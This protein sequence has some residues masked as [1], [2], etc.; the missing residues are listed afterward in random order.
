MGGVF[1]LGFIL[2]GDTERSVGSSLVADFVLSSLSLLPDLS[3]IE[4]YH[5][6]SPQDDQRSRQ[7]D[8]SSHSSNEIARENTRYVFQVSQDKNVSKRSFSLSLA[9]SA[10]ST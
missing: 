7:S 10:E 9:F 8:L 3:E 5:S 1:L 4:S 2:R 6:Y